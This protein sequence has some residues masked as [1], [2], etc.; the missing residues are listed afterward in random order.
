MIN[1]DMILTQYYLK[2]GSSSL[3]QI[4]GHTKYSPFH[5]QRELL[6]IIILCSHTIY[7]GVG[8]FILLTMY[9]YNL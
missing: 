5:L 4:F 3:G 7:S 6:L 1:E 2:I 8:F 9:P